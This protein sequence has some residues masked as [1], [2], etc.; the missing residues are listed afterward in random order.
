M[1]ERPTDRLDGEH[2]RHAVTGSRTDAGARLHPLH[3]RRQHRLVGSR[4]TVPMPQHPARRG[5]REVQR[6]PARAACRPEPL[7]PRPDLEASTPRVNRDPLRRPFAQPGP[8]DARRLPPGRS[9]EPRPPAGV[10][11][12]ALTVAISRS[13]RWRARSRCGVR[14]WHGSASRG[15]LTR[16][17][18]IVTSNSAALPRA[19]RTRSTGAH[20]RRLKATM[21]GKWTIP[22]ASRIHSASS[23]DEASGGSSSTGNPA[24]KART[25]R[26]PCASGGEA[27][28]TASTTRAS[29]SASTESN[30]R[31]PGAD[32]A[33]NW[34]RSAWASYAAVR[35][36][37][38]E[39]ADGGQIEPFRRPAA[40]KQAEEDGPAHG[41]SPRCG[42]T[43]RSWSSRRRRQW[44]RRVVRGP[45]A[46]FRRV[47]VKNLAETDT[48][49]N[50]GGRGRP[51]ARVTGVLARCAA[52][53]LG[54]SHPID[55]GQLALYHTSLSCS[56]CSRLA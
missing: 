54:G 2:D 22:S 46:V 25:A 31:Q 28:T 8:A 7:R 24:P 26:V 5:N 17:L 44:V 53:G 39:A 20:H 50:A 21:T 11:R 37:F 3:E 23:G 48:R 33:M 30:G 49:A 51:W 43:G 14:A 29:M 1:R 9:H 40:A 56:A 45:G 55:S 27:I 52:G 10:S 12:R 13:S 34:R 32:R 19:R 36:A 41:A 6:S 18:S 38:V 4:Q 15:S 42:R 47:R 35:R 16:T